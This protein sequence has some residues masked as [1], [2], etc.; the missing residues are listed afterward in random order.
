MAKGYGFV[1]NAAAIM[2]GDKAADMVR[3][4]HADCDV[5]GFPGTGV[6]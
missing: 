6:P 1:V 4:D 2:I 3:D 5:E